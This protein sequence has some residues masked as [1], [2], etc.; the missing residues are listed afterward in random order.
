MPDLAQ[1]GL[2][3]SIKRNIIRE[4]TLGSVRLPISQNNVNTDFPF[5]VKCCFSE[6]GISG[7]FQDLVP[8]LGELV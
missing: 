8:I 7:S 3:D 6:R 1:T 4:S 2:Q 5:K